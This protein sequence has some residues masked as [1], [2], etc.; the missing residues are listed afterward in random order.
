MK[1]VSQSAKSTYT[2]ATST[3]SGAGPK[4]HQRVENSDGKDGKKPRKRGVPYETVSLKVDPNNLCVREG[5]REK[6]HIHPTI[7]I[8][9]LVFHRPLWRSDVAVLEKNEND[10]RFLLG[11]MKTALKR[12]RE[13]QDEVAKL[14]R[15][16]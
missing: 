1:E 3:D 12:A 11:C 5:W 2:A 7:S 8:F 9:L 6:N 15:C 13:R 4:K 14:R 16:V 10:L